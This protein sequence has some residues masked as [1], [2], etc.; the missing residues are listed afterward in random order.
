[1]RHQRADGRLP[2]SIQ[3]AG[4]V[5]EPQFNK[6]QGFCFP[7]PALNLYY[8]TGRDG[9]WL[10]ALADCLRRFDDYLWKTRAVS[11]D[12]LLS[13]FCVYDTGEDNAVRFGQLWRNPY[14]SVCT[15]S[16]HDMPML[17]QWWDENWERAQS[18]YNSVLWHD[19]PAP[20]P[21]P[22]WL[23]R[24]IVCQHLASPSMLCLLSLQDWLATD[25]TLRH[26]DPNSERINIP[27]NSRHYWRWRM[28]LTLE[29]LMQADDFNDSIRDM[30]TRSGRT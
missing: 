3:C 4:G 21:M 16:T 2:G 20:H 23:A 18:Y 13:A 14:R 7:A 26:P 17:R 12:G 30:I 15:I 8:L 27:A 29:Q 9:D 19:G 24:D 6:F 5:V 11:G 28:P 10:D 1:M 22:G 25:E